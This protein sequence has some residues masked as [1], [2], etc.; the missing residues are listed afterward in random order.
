MAEWQ[1]R[2]W[3]TTA[4][5]YAGVVVRMLLG[6]V[7]FRLMFQEFTG[8][9]FGFWALLWSLFGYG[10]LLDFGFGFTAQKAVAEKTAT[11]DHE[12]LSRLLSTILWTF[13]G[14]AVALL[15]VFLLIR[16]PFLSRMGVEAADRGAFGDAYLVFFIGLALMFPLGLFPEILRGLQ[17]IDIANWLG[18]LSTVLNFIF[19]YWGLRAGWS[20]AILMM[21]SV[22][23]TI[24]PNLVA[25]VVA[26]RQLPGVS[27]SPRWF[28]WRSVRSQMG[29]SVAA[30]LITFSN[31]LMAKSDQLVISMSLGVAL[32][33]IYQAGYKMG[34]MLGLFSTQLQQVLSPAAAAMHATGDR[35]GLR[36]LLLGSS[37]LTFFLVTPC[38]LLSAVYLDPLIRLLTGMESVSMDTWWVGQAL[39]FAVYSSQLTSGC[40]KRVLMMCGEERRLLAISLVDAVANVVLS[41]ILAYRFGVLGVA[42]GT[43]I[44]TTL[45]GWLWVVPLTIRR[46]GISVGAYVG[47]HL[48]GTVVPMTVFG[49]VLA[50]LF[51]WVPADDSTGI[52]GLGWRGAVCMIPFL[53]F[54]RNVI[55]GI[56]RP[57]S[58]T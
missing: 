51:L 52:V 36:H 53:W 12:G 46:L 27:F 17:R 38:Y 50:A 31:M 43:M 8:A 45:V 47:H 2:F 28:E 21:V 3:S 14:M 5:G 37:R 55:G 58:T 54:G 23:T 32:V 13:I 57:R 33:A 6:L 19:L 4:S 25:A 34:E 15:V 24:L 49:A 44:P 16:E 11:A 7:L 30:Y 20:L 39:L 29:F 35:E 9:E 18:T 56:T 48:R 22:V 40:S 42:L 26:I 41:I 1:R 10:I